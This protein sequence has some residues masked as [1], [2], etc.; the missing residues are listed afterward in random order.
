M[1][2]ASVSPRV[3]FLGAFGGDSLSGRTRGIVGQGMCAG[4]EGGLFGGQL[5][6]SGVAEV[7]RILS[8]FDSVVSGSSLSVESFTRMGS[9]LSVFCGPSIL[10]PSGAFLCGTSVSAMIWST[11]ELSIYSGINSYRLSRNEGQLAC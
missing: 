11:G 4:N 2:L 5:S 1:I 8:V 9:A 7:C 3:Y 10:S 6:V